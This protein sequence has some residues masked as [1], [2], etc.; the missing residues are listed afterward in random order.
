MPA[1]FI[2]RALAPADVLRMLRLALPITLGQLAVVGMTVTDI[3]VAGRASTDDLAAV[4]LGS[5]VFNLSIMLVIGIVLANSPI[6]GQAHGAGDFVGVRRQL[7]NCLWLSLPLGLFAAACIAVGIGILAHIGTTPVI[8]AIA[9]GYLWPML[10][11]GFLMPFMLAFRTSFEGMG[12]ARPAMLFNVLGFALNIPL[13]FALVQGWWGLPAMGGA[14]CGWATLIVV[15]LIVV[16]EALYAHFSVTFARYRLFAAAGLPRW[17]VIR[18]TLRIG[19]PIGGAILAEGGFF[20]LIPLLVA[21][22]GAVVVSGHAV[23]ITV[24]WMMFMVPLGISQAIAVLVANAIGQHDAV[25]ARRVCATGLVLTATIALVQASVVIL[26][27]EPIAALYS[28]DTGV[29]ALASHLLM[30]AAAFRV[31]D[32]INVGGN[33]ALRGY[34]DTRITLVLAL[35]AYWIVGFPLSYSLALTSV[36]G[37]PMGVEGFWVGMVVTLAL[38]ACLTTTRVRRTSRRAIGIAAGGHPVNV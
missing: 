19:L 24:D 8:A 25:N 38:T 11:S 20:L 31:F 21:P 7:Q 17:S 1:T 9:R 32:A 6:T 15:L 29:R 3:L 23:A 35:S 10:G 18:E 16:S 28:E 34:Q 14:G 13:A 37:Q 12:H 2:H 30:Y 5:T 36:W 4:T 22:L 26:F 33:G 27:R